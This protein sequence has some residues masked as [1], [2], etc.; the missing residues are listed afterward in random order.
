[1]WWV[2]MIVG[3]FLASRMFGW[4]GM[5]G[6]WYRHNPWVRGGWGTVVITRP[7]RC[8]HARH[9][10]HHAHWR[11]TSQPVQPSVELTAAQKRERAMSEL[12]RRY[13]AD[14]ISVEEY[15]RELDRVLRE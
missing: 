5:R 8:G 4:R 12:R 15:E 11:E 1:M 9:R 2:W 3:V 7:H 10:A 13:V 14:E 6:R